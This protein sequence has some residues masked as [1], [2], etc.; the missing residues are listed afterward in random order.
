ME[1]LPLI[2]SPVEF[3]SKFDNCPE[4]ADDPV[5]KLKAI[6]ELLAIENLYEFFEVLDNYGGFIT[7]KDINNCPEL[8]AKFEFAEKEMDEMIKMMEELLSI[9]SPAEFLNKFDNCPELAD[10]PVLKKKTRSAKNAIRKLKAINELLV[11]ENSY[12]FFEVLDDYGGFITLKDINNCPELKAK[13]ECAGKEMDE[14]TKM[15]DEACDV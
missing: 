13:F 12:E 11:I 15:M 3:L 7:L 8:K 9:K 14:M 6:N 2:E 1:E 10:D 4:L 5:L